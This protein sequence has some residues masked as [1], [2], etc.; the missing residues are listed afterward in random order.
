MVIVGDVIT[1]LRE[2]ESVISCLIGSRDGGTPQTP[3]SLPELP[4]GTS[5]WC[6]SRF[7][8]RGVAAIDSG[9]SEAVSR[10]ARCRWHGAP[11][12]TAGTAGSDGVV[13]GRG[14]GRWRGWRLR[15]RR[16]RQRTRAVGCRCGRSTAMARRSAAVS[17]RQV[18]ARSGAGMGAKRGGCGGSRTRHAAHAYV[19]A[20]PRRGGLAAAAAAP[21]NAMRSSERD[22]HS[23]RRPIV[24]AS[25][26]ER[27]APPIGRHCCARTSA[28]RPRERSSAH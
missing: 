11:T 12:G 24:V 25:V 14:R 9:C 15:R 4:A 13:G 3:R 5:S 16:P 18:G 6:A 7:A 22:G 21:T 28:A 27:N 26:L 20:Y 10:R 17:T 1:D 8:W 2:S 19:V 23:Q